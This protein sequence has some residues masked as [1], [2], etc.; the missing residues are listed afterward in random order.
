[1]GGMT[2]TSLDGQLSG[3]NHL[4]KLFLIFKQMHFQRAAVFPP[5]FLG[6][7]G[8]RTNQA[9]KTRWIRK[10]RNCSLFIKNKGLRKL[11]N[12]LFFLAGGPGTPLH[13]LRCSHTSSGPV[14]SVI[15]KTFELLLNNIFDGSN[16]F[17]RQRCKCPFATARGKLAVVMANQDHQVFGQS[18]RHF[19]CGHDSAQGFIVSL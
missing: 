15:C 16:L 3:Y 18:I 6:F 5:S 12:T 7:D 19:D 13:L 1:M 9:Q 17:I 10:W 8:R 11:C 4:S 2:T 14:C